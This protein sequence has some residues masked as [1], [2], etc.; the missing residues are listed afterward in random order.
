MAHVEIYGLFDPRDGSLRY[1][2]KA[3]C[4]AKRF[5]SHLRDSRRRK[6]PLYAWVRKLAGGGLLPV[7][8]VVLTCD[9]SEWQMWER[10]L[11]AAARETGDSLLNVAAGGDEP[12]CPKPVLAENGKRAAISR[13]D[14]PAKARVYHLK[15]YFGQLLR[16]GKVSEANKE[17][18]RYAA[19]RAPHLFGCFA[20]V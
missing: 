13:V 18:L 14:T 3:N 15:R 1:I 2:G 17:K 20:N 11:I 4:A 5:R 16:K 10:R 6:T 19:C 8:R 9:R 12:Y 7:L